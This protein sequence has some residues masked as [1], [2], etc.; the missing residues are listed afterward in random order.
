MQSILAFPFANVPDNLHLGDTNT[1]G[2]IPILGTKAILQYIYQ[3]KPSASFTP[4]LVERC[5]AVLQRWSDN[6][7]QDAEGAP[8]DS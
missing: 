1:G 4:D 2:Y 3:H 7:E 5:R 8:E 6:S